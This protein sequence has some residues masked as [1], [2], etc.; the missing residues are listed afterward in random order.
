[1]TS[2]ARYADAIDLFD[3]AYSLQVDTLLIS[4]LQVK[5]DV[6]RSLAAKT[7][8]SA[9]IEIANLSEA[10]RKRLQGMRNVFVS[11]E[12]GYAQGKSLIFRGDLREVWSARDGTE[13]ITT[14]TSGDGEKARKKKRLNQSF[15]AG[16]PVS[17]L[18]SACA[19]ALGV[20]I[21]NAAKKGGAAQL[22]RASPP[23]RLGG[24]A[25]TG[26]ALAQL[27]RVCR[28]CGIEWS[29]QDNQL[30][31]LERGK[32][33]Q[34]Q[35]PKLSAL[36]GMVGSPE[37]GKSGLVRVRTV[38]VPNLQ[39]GRKVELDSLLVKGIYRIETAHFIGDFE[40]ADWGAELELKPAQ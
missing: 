1:M 26:D 38:M 25:F 23:K 33:L 19:K 2:S 28:S 14:V 40:G 7:P 36:S 9:K 12:A 30:Q 13:W 6:Q 4:A 34:E 18:I 3:R 31:L 10:T 20:G 22:F 35:G 5:F 21:G 17:A 29:I 37:V 15:P 11:L 24:A 32:A 39:P 16:T 27:D 8:N